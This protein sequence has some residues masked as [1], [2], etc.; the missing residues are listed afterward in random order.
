MKVFDTY[1]VSSQS[2]LDLSARANAVI[3]DIWERFGRFEFALVTDGANASEV[4]SVELPSEVLRCLSHVLDLVAQKK[5]FSVILTDQF[6]TTQDVAD[7]LNVSRGF[8]VKEIDAG[9]IDCVRVGNQRRVHMS[10]VHEY[11]RLYM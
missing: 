8:V 7:F 10:N 9:R 4:K 6:L 2:D 5:P 1:S 11:M 3:K